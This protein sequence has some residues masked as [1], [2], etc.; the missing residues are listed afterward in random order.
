MMRSEVRRFQSKKAAW[1]CSTANWK[2]CQASFCVNTSPNPPVEAPALQPGA[3]TGVP[4]SG[5][6]LGG[7]PCL[8]SSFAL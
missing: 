7:S 1:F 6:G 2:N 4:C 8:I 3:S 5:Q